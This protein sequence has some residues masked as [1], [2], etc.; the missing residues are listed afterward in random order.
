[1]I[2]ES[3]GQRAERHGVL[4]EGGNE[5]FSLILKIVV[6]VFLLI[7]AIGF[8]SEQ[9]LPVMNG[10]KMVATVNDETITLDELSQEISSLKAGK[11]TE[12]KGTRILNY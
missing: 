4:E 6:T 9:E 5:T 3:S 11:S 7:V 8:A 2:S 1:M 12:Q 10:K